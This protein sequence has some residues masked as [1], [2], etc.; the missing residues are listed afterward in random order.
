M[1]PSKQDIFDYT[2]SENYN[3]DVCFGI[4]FDEASNG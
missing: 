2:L 4:T 1:Y 3:E